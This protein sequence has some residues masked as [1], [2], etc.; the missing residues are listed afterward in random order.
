MFSNSLTVGLPAKTQSVLD[1][2]I[3]PKFNYYINFTLPLKR[4][5]PNPAIPTEFIYPNDSMISD[6]MVFYSLFADVYE[7]LGGPCPMAQFSKTEHFLVDQIEKIVEGDGD[8]SFWHFQ[9]DVTQPIPPMQTQLSDVLRTLRNGFAHM[10]WFY[11]NLSAIDY[12]NAMGWEI[13]NSIPAFDLQNRPAK[14]YM[15]YIAD[16][17]HW[18]TKEFWKLDNLRIIVTRSTVLRYR[19]HLF[20]NYLLNGTKV[21]VFGNNVN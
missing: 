20:L 15:T 16:G 18:G 7:A 10:H 3:A 6:L 14:N 8:G 5:Q 21:D 2:V 12:W 4:Y 13:A 1:T 11:D 17:K 9:Q 19:L